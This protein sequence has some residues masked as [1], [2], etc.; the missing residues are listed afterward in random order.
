VSG[1]TVDPTD[2]RSRDA[3]TARPPLVYFHAF[4]PPSSG[5]VPVVMHRL[6]ARLG[7]PLVT[8]TDRRNRS[9]GPGAAW[10][11]GSYRYF[12]K[13]PPWNR[14]AIYRWPFGLANVVLAV[15]A[16]IRAGLD[17]RR[18]GAGWV[19]SVADDGF[20][21]IGGHVAA[22]VAG[23]P[24]VLWVFDLWG[25]NAFMDVD[26]W[27]ARRLEGPIWRR[28]SAI[29]VHTDKIDEL[30][31]R[32]HGVG[33]RVVPTPGGPIDADDGQREPERS[34]PYEVV[35]GGAVYWAQEE[36]MRRL[37]RVCREM[38]DV[39]LTYI[40]DGSG[41]PEKEIFADRVEAQ[42]DYPEF[43]RRLRDAD[44]LFLGLSFDSTAPAIVRT[45][46]PARLVDFMASGRPLLIH[47]PP[48]THVAT[49]A[50]SE[51]FAEVVDLPS[52]EALVAGLRRVLE[53]PE[54]SRARVDRAK[55]LAA[56]SHDPERV[57]GRLLEILDQIRDRQEGDGG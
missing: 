44:I 55:D 56:V 1:T 47:A 20:S 22:R 26:R 4:A 48:D 38:P 41:L 37:S 36:A 33:C 18:I 5:G 23:V 25:E 3:G 40:G 34:A 28:A 51:D 46:T 19:L 2:S 8:F 17:A 27:L 32:K 10:L 12:L 24:H 53:D 14:F 43:R 50:R 39:T 6:L 29:V 52:D 13:I 35:T 11:P 31:R 42:T 7:V 15:F 45:G 16:G 57:R 49:Y 30:Y 9:V 21:P 54:A